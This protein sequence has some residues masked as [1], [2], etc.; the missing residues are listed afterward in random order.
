MALSLWRI[1]FS[2]KKTIS[3][4][5][6]SEQPDWSFLHPD[7]IRLTSR[8]LTDISDFVRFRV[9]C[10][11][12]RRAV[13]ASDLAPQ[14]P[15]I[16]DD[17]WGF[18]KG[19]L[20]FY[21]LLTNKTYTVNVDQ[22]FYPDHRYILGSIYNYIPIY[23]WETRECSLFNPLTNEELSLP[24]AKSEECQ[25]CV[26]SDQSSRYVCV[27]NTPNGLDAFLYS[28]QLGDLK[29]T[30]IQPV[31]NLDIG[32]KLF[33]DSG[34][35]LYD[36][37]F[38]ANDWETGCTK[39]INLVTRT[40]VCVVPRPE[41]E[42]GVPVCLV[43]SFGEILRVCQYHKYK[44][45]KPYYFDIYRLELGKRD[46]NVVHPCWTKIDRIGNQF[47][48]LHEDPGCAFRADDF[49]GFIGN[50]IYFLREKAVGKTEINRYDMKY[51]KIEVREVPIK[52]GRSWFVPS[53]CKQSSNYRS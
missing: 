40:A 8:K 25:S 47:L 51:G 5:D 9:V 3:D 1:L 28:C 34:F 45:E 37:M 14:L 2:K 48:F 29:W 52:L 13:H 10:K 30:S 46:G 17:H 39:V 26:P 21:S 35:A 42:L 36:E 32:G 18:N 15:W 43:V 11:R 20:R 27:T 4:T 22:Y 23:N 19:Y 50:S 31:S 53:L 49:P 38:Y 6:G 44:T 7:L 33:L 41:P 12:W 24:R 16:M